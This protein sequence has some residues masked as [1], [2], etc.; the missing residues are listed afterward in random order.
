MV[1]CAS[2]PLVSVVI[3]FFDVEAYIA[4]SI[5][6]VIAQSHDRWELIL[7]DDGGADE[8]RAIVDEYC[9]RFPHRIRCL[10]HPDRENRGLSAS[11]NLGWEA[12]SG[13]F[14]AF[15]DADDVWVKDK[16]AIQLA[17]FRENPQVDVCVG[18]SLYWHEWPGS[19][20]N[21]PD[22]VYY[23]GGPQDTVLAPG[24]LVET[25]YPLGPA[26]A[27]SMNTVMLRREAFEGEQLFEPTFRTTF[28]DQAF[29]IKAYLDRC[30][31]VSSEVLDYYRKG[32]P[33]SITEH[34]L[35]YAIR[36]RRQM[37]FYA[38]LV[39]Y[40]KR[41]GSDCRTLAWVARRWLWRIRYRYCRAKLESLLRSLRIPFTAR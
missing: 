22:E 11:R 32:R 23:A 34:E 4:Q 5:E 38:W 28:E 40:L 25:N 37:T 19:C 6:S 30:F 3:S 29:L 20:S 27:P 33:D 16:L 35:T 26:V 17:I 9:Q 13:E 7:I 21:L 18:A 36:H 39:V 24:A 1:S 15:L 14:V 12:A 8:S 2:S 10:Q 31:Y 41:R